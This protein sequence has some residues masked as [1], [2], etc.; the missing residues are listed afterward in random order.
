MTRPLVVFSHANGFPAGSYRKLFDELSQTADI[1]APDMLGHDPAWPVDDNWGNLASE[2][3]A[4]IR[5]RA[6]RPV[7]GV[8]HSLGAM[9]TFFAAYREPQRFRGIVMLDPPV[10]NGLGAY[11]F[12]LLKWLGRAD[13]L[14]PAGKSR[15]RRTSWP[16]RE[17]A[18]ADLA[19]KK[20]FAAFDPD[21]LRD[22]VESGTEPGGEGVQLRYRL[23]VELAGF[24]TTPSNPHRFLRPLRVPGLLLTGEQSDVALPAHIAR[25]HRRHRLL[26]RVVPGGHLFPLEQP[27]ATARHVAKQLQDWE[28]A[29]MSEVPA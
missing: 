13:P 10:I 9:V 5:A 19:R 18:L 14:T 11:S 17:A 20:L 21:C 7:Y 1:I 26:H 28:R 24:R 25:L 29:R 22:Y 3:L 4:F 2:L 6:D 16:S 23:P 12:Q 8:G 15:F 27:L